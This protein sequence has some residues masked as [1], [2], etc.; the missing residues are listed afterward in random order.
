MTF[1][2]YTIG[3]SAHSAEAFV[4]LLKA[5]GITAVADVRSS[6]YSRRFPQ[7]SRDELRDT[8]A[9]A[10]IKYVFLGKELGARRAELDS[11]D[12]NRVD[13]LRVA[14]Q[15]AFKS[16]LQRVTTGA[17]SHVIALVCAEKD[18]I[19]CHRAMLVGW[20][21]ALEGLKVRHIHADSTVETHE[22]LKGRL[23]EKYKM[24]ADLFS[25]EEESLA[26]AYREQSKKIAWEDAAPE[27]DEN[28]S[29]A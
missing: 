2:V 14:R 10:G 8:L 9:A 13:Y 29:D 20:N 28:R 3:H 5:H 27:S 7:F 1:P 16:G 25:S 15:P 12:G 21:L 24:G 4:E 26:R 23:L 22:E 19:E 6:P 18:P 11:F 17:Q